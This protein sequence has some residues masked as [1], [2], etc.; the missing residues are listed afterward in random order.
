[1]P[2]KATPPKRGILTPLLTQSFATLL[3]RRKVENW[4]A[5]ATR[6]L[7]RTVGNWLAVT[8]QRPKKRLTC[9]MLASTKQALTVFRGRRAATRQ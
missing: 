3:L 7:C 8:M 4:L 9:R 2:P 6:L 5:I 1:M